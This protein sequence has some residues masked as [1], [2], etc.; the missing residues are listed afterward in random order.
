MWTP[1][2]KTDSSMLSTTKELGTVSLDPT[3]FTGRF[4]LTTWT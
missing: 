1:F 3:S 4:R 2:T